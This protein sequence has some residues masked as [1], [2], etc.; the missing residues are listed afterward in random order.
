PERV[1]LIS[2]YVR[3]M[4][5]H[6]STVVALTPELAAYSTCDG[7]LLDPGEARDVYIPEDVELRTNWPVLV[8][9]YLVSGGGL[10]PAS[11]DPAL[12][13]VPPVEQFRDG[14]TVGVP[15]QYEAND[16]EIVAEAGGSVVLDGSEI[17]L[18]LEPFA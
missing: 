13:F 17:G 15:E 1:T 14:Y 2:D 5:Q 12:A 18:I 6:E 7:N 4:A 9:H 11:G 10:G 16:L 3:V 8:A